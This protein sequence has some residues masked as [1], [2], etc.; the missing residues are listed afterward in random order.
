MISGGFDPPHIGHI[1]LIK[2][3]SNYGKV[4]VAL[5]SDEWLTR[6][7][8]KPF[9]SWEERAETLEQIK[10]VSRVVVVDDRDGTVCDA[11]LRIQPDFFANGGDRKTPNPLEDEVCRRLKITQLFGIGGEKIRSSRDAA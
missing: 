2:E 9:M 1:R 8:G 7:K 11:L 3:A 5:N 6:K 4:I 10:G